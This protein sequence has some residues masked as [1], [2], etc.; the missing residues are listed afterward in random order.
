MA[1]EKI[2]RMTH[3]NPSADDKKHPILMLC[4]TTYPN[5]AYCIN[6]PA[7][8]IACIEY[9][10]SGKGHV[11]INGQE[12]TIRAGDTYY[13]P[14]GV[15]QFYHADRDEPWEKIWVNFSGDFSKN[16]A[17]LCGVDGIFHYPNL[18]TSDLLQKFQHYATSTEH[19][20]A[21]ERCSALLAQ[22]FFRLSGS[23]YA[24]VVQTSPVDNMLL[25]IEQHATEALTLEQIAAVC[26]K[27][28]SQAERLFRAQT[29]VSLYH[30]VLEQKISIARQLLTET[31]MTVKEI[32]AYLS[33]NDEFYFSGLFRR[34][35]GIAP[36]KYRE[37]GGILK[38]EKTVDIF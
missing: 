2:L 33:F 32:A 8:G 29:G 24:P 22:L 11:W 7:S 25:Y 26:G 21:F 1:H 19:S 38:I 34:M 28:V 9:V 10:V 15:D 31:G 30:Y 16:L 27:S 6:R 4:G 5:K 17:T 18:N 3:L 14:E 20:L 12:F 35:V 13:L 37:L 23:I 36:S